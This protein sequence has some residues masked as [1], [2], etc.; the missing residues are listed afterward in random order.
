MSAK[1]IV[2]L[3]LALFVAAA[4][5]FVAGKR[6]GRAEAPSPSAESAQPS[7]ER[8]MTAYYFHGGTRCMTCYRLETY[9]EE[10]IQEHFPEQLS[11]GRLVWKPVDTDVPENKHFVEEFELYTKHVV[12]V[13]RKGGEQVRWKDLEKIWDL[14]GD[15]AAYQDYI[16]DEV[17]AFMGGEA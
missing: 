8:T 10:A 17:K 7:A 3:I 1:N 11:S 5:G 9:A 4:L 12:L 14:V 13:E 2:A 6:F 15:E 16:R